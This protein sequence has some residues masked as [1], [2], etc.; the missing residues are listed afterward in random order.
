[1]NGGHF[2]HDAARVFALQD[3]DCRLLRQLGN[4][5]CQ[6]RHAGHNRCRASRDGITNEVTTITMAAS[7]RKKQIAG[8]NAL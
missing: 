8:R 4:V 1:M 2:G 7:K 3:W 6:W 5:F